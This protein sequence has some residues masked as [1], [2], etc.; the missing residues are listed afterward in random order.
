MIDKTEKVAASKV[1]AVANPSSTDQPIVVEFHGSPSWAINLPFY[2]K[3]T[4]ALIGGLGI[5]WGF[6]NRM[7]VRSVDHARSAFYDN[8][9]NCWNS[10]RCRHACGKHGANTDR[11]R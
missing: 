7:E 9:G 6:G 8:R 11:D 5:V 1:R 3:C 10:N 4:L 2:L